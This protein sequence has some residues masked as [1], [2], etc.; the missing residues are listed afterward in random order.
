MFRNVRI[1]FVF[2]CLDLLLLSSCEKD[3][4]GAG[5]Q[6]EMEI[7]DS[8][9]LEVNTPVLKFAGQ[10]PIE[11]K[12]LFYAPG[13]YGYPTSNQFLLETDIK[14]NILNEIPLFDEEAIGVGNLISSVGYLKDGSI[15]IVT[16]TGVFQ[17]SGKDTFKLVIK[18]LLG[19]PLFLNR[20]LSS[21]VIDG[22]TSIAC[23]HHFIEALNGK[24]G[25]KEYIDKYRYFTIYNLSEGEMDMNGHI[26]KESN[27][28]KY[29]KPY[30]NNTVATAFSGTMAYLVQSPSSDLWVYDMSNKFSESVVPMLPENYKVEDFSISDSRLRMTTSSRYLDATAIGDSVLVTYATGFDQEGVGRQVNLTDP[31]VQQRLYLENHKIYGILIVDGRKVGN[32]IKLEHP[33]SGDI[34]A[35]RDGNFLLGV[36]DG[37]VEMIQ[38]TKYYIGRLVVHQ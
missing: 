18:D 1:L 22:D 35:M 12:L 24:Q 27:L 26:P 25:T 28:A 9:Y 11:D 17:L 36:N 38:G 33:L 3:F 14:G 4:E 23:I 32:D 31:K 16:D 8:I 2:L 7:I 30:M 5:T 10:S 6:V 20:E 29:P 19:T 34:L 13:G 15:A 21:F 37:L